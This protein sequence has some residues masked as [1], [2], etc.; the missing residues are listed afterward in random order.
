MFASE[1]IQT[2]QLN[3]QHVFHEDVSEVVSDRVAFVDYWKGILANGADATKTGFSEQSAFVN[4]LEESGI[5]FET[6]NTALS[7]R[8]VTES[9]SRSSVFILRSIAVCRPTRKLL[10]TIMASAYRD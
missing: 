9:K 1:A 6:S 5:V 8:A 10:K 4:F 3:H 2:F 7:T